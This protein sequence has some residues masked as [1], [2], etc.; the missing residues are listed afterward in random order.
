MTPFDVVCINDSFRPDGIPTSKWVR[1]GEIYTVVEVGKMR[2]Q[3]GL[4]GFKLKQ[5]NIDDCIPYQFFSADRFRMLQDNDLWV[6]QVL[7]EVVEEAKKELI[8]IK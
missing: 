7:M 6:E 2:R 1:K 4:L 5:I 3:G 8:D